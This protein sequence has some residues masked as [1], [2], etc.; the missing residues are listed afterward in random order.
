[1]QT[2]GDELAAALLQQTVTCEERRARRRALI[3]N[4]PFDKPALRFRRRNL[5]RI[6]QDPCNPVQPPEITRLQQLLE[7][8]Q[9][10]PDNCVGKRV[11]RIPSVFTAVT[12]RRAVAE[13]YENGFIDR[14]PDDISRP[15][16]VA[17][18]T[19]TAGLNG[20]GVEKKFAQL[21]TISRNILQ[22]PK[23]FCRQASIFNCQDPECTAAFCVEYGFNDSLPTYESRRFHGQTTLGLG[24]GVDGKVSQNLCVKA[25]RF[26]SGTASL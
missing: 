7:P 12:E 3:R 22:R 17:N 2:P 4:A 26:G 5:F 15:D 6:T 11:C 21:C 24:G 8:E 14:L 13:C 10:N 19:G 18:Y 23:T 16:R 25:S 1:M 9:T 20:Q